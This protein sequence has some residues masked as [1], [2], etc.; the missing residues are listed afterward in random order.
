[1][2]RNYMIQLLI[3]IVLL[4]LTGCGS[5]EKAALENDIIWTN[6]NI[7]AVQNNPENETFIVFRSGLFR[8][9]YH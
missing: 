5:D 6:N 9:S 2:K 1:M 3:F 8:Y 4:A 7:Q